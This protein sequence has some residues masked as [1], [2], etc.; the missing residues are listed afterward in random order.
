MLKRVLE[1]GAPKNNDATRRKTKDIWCEIERDLIM[2]AIR[3]YV[4]LYSWPSGLSGLMQG[5]S[6]EQGVRIQYNRPPM[7][8]ANHIHKGEPFHRRWCSCL[9]VS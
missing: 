1:D 7:L 5:A 6:T 4:Q 8:K 9:L 2:A 3:G